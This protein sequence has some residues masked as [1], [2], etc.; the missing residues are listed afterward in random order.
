LLPFSVAAIIVEIP[1]VIVTTLTYSSIFYW[2]V[3]L[4]SAGFGFFILVGFFYNMLGLSLGQLVAAA[5][6]SQAIAQLV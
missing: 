6:G 1:Y 5:I 3:G 4:E 2:L